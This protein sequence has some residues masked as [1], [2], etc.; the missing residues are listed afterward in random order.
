M[1]KEDIKAFFQKHVPHMPE[2]QRIHKWIKSQNQAAA[3]AIVSGLLLYGWSDEELLAS[4]T[5]VIVA[6]KPYLKVAISE[7]RRHKESQINQP[8]S[9]AL[10]S[11]Y[12]STSLRDISDPM[13]IANLASSVANFRCIH[14]VSN[15]R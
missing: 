12:G 7:G 15:V 9:S 6:L 14:R 5:M 2:L 8:K 1:S 4:E 13:V 10:H 3:T 11:N